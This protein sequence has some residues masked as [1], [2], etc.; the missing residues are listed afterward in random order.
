MCAQL[1]MH[2][3]G[4]ILAHASV[5]Q[6]RCHRTPPQYRC[7]NQ[8]IKRATQARNALR[9]ASLAHGLQING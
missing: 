5:L 6:S 7:V 9:A 3:I 8:S 4:S 2:G 1:Q